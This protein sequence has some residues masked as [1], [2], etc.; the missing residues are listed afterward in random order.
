MGKSVR[1]CLLAYAAGLCLESGY[2]WLRVRFGHRRRESLSAS[3][4]RIT[5]IPHAYIAR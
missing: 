4:G 1:A 2:A 3:E 5:S